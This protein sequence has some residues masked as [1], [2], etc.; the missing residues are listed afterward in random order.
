[1]SRTLLAIAGY[2]ALGGLVD[3]SLALAMSPLS[4]LFCLGSG[5]KPDTEPIV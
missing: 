1:L 5:I 2:I 3:P 4:L